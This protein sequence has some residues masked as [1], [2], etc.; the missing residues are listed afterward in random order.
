M[1]WTLL[2]VH[3][4]VDAWRNLPS[5]YITANDSAFCCSCM[6]RVAERATKLHNKSLVCHQPKDS[7]TDSHAS[8]VVVMLRRPF[9]A[10]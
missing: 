1:E 8:V 4:F 7:K 3:E 9:V 10:V 2:K 5:L 6:W